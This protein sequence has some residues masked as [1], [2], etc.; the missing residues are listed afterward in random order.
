MRLNFAMK[1]FQNI[2]NEWPGFS[3]AHSGISFCLRHQAFTAKDRR[4]AISLLDSALVA[5][6]Q[7][8]RAD[9]FDASAHVSQGR[10]LMLNG[11]INDAFRHFQLALELDEHS[12]WGR[13]M[14]MQTM[15]RTGNFVRSIELGGQARKSTKD[16]TVLA[17]L[18]LTLALGQLRIGNVDEARSNAQ[19]CV[20]RSNTYG[21]MIYLAALIFAESGNVNDSG[22]QNRGRIPTRCKNETGIF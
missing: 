13:Y 4:D 19:R 14:T 21:H 9:F 18:D 16:Q 17:S 22:I 7:A 3:K 20:L 1:Q 12:D 5:S 2:T 15:M 6:E 11:D 10:A 8:L